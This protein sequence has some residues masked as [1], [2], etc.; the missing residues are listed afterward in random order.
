MDLEV[1]LPLLFYAFFLFSLIF[2]SRKKIKKNKSRSFI[3]YNNNSSFAGSA[4]HTFT[5]ASG[6][7]SGVVALTG[8]MAI[9]APGSLTASMVNIAEQLRFGRLPTIQTASFSVRTDQLAPVY[10]IDTSASVV[11]ASLFAISGNSDYTGLQ[12]I[13]KDV[14]GSGST[15]SF[16]LSCSAPDTID[17]AA[18]LSMSADYGAIGLIADPDEAQWWIIFDRS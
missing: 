3:Q 15:N 12:L 2:S 18:A 8:S 6:G 4:Y 17:G 1:I 9:V 5:T 16:I 11:T 14:G 13:F 10:R 7:A